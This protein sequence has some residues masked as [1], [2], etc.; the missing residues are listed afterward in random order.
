MFGVQMPMEYVSQKRKKS[1]MPNRSK[2]EMAGDEKDYHKV[3]GKRADLKI[4]KKS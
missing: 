2:R 1:R 3:K 4:S